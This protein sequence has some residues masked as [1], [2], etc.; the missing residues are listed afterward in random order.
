MSGDS[1]LDGM[2]TS[3]VGPAQVRLH[4]ALLV[5]SMRLFVSTH[6]EEIEDLICVNN[7]V[8]TDE[9]ISNSGWFTFWHQIRR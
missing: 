7:N 6:N 9:V 2:H 5:V 8:H 4:P 3:G 1:T